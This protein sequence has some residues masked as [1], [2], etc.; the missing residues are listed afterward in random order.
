MQRIRT[1]YSHNTILQ[2]I[3]KAKI[4]DN[5]RISSILIKKSYRIELNKC[6]IINNILYFRNCIFILNNKQLRIVIIQYFYKALLIS[7]LD[8][9]D[10]YKLVNQHYY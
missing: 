9:I 5:R 10:I 2:V 6:E 8:K 4:N 1:M 3:V 7:Y